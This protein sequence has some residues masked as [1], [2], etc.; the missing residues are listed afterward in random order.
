MQ[1]QPHQALIIKRLKTLSVLLVC[2]TIF[3]ACN[4]DKTLNETS[5]QDPNSD[6]LDTFES[7]IDVLTSSENE[8]EDAQDN[9]QTEFPKGVVADLKFSTIEDD[10][11]RQQEANKNPPLFCLN[12]P[13]SD[14]SAVEACNR[15]SNRLASVSYERC[16]AAKLSQTGCL[17]VSQF[18]IL[19]REFPPLDEVKPKGRVLV[20]GGTHGDE[21]TSVS[22]M[23]RWI[24][25][26]NRFHSGRFHWHMVPM[27]NPDGVLKKEATRTNQN[28]VDL[29]RNLPSEDWQA[30]AHK[31]WETKGSKNARKYPG[32]NAASE[33]E[34]QF[35]IDEINSFKPDAIIAVHAPYGIVDFDSQVLRGAPKSLGK[36]HLNLLG[37]YPGSLGN[38]AG[39]NRNIPVITLE[40]PHSWVMPSEEESSKIWEDLVSWLNRSIGPELAKGESN[41][42][43]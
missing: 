35:L 2:C 14:Y 23:F 42:G 15:I 18:P 8:N 16:A 41:S 13:A 43:Y 34:V 5:E 22:I 39:I 25:K 24:E 30:L 28:G 11:A 31:Y 37:T 38:Y 1:F 3:V 26:L 33:P 4:Q 29:N 21:L 9:N 17:S 27:M 36:L 19:M 20:I 10:I 12:K 40:L 7:K 32:K 6:K